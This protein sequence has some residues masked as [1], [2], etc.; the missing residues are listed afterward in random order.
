MSITQSYFMDFLK[1]V[2]YLGWHCVRYSFDL[3][4]ILHFRNET[5]NSN[6]PSLPPPPIAQTEN[7]VPWSPS[8]A[9]GVIALVEN[10]YRPTVNTKHATTLRRNTPWKPSE[11]VRHKSKTIASWRT[12][13]GM[14]I[15]TA[16]IAWYMPTVELPLKS[17]HWPERTPE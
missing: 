13:C 2:R 10:R 7:T 1:S 15:P 8:P 12:D 5:C 3:E 4:S 11:T 14:G 6:E 9:D 17:E 16:V